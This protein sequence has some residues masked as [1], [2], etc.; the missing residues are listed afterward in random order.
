MDQD[1]LI[2]SLKLQLRLERASIALVVFIFIG[3]W[4]VG[5]FAGRAYVITADGKPLAY[6]ATHEAAERV[7]AQVK[8]AVAGAKP[9]D[10]SFKESVEIRK[11]PSDVDVAPEDDAVKSVL[12]KVSLR[13]KKHAILVEGVPAVAVDSEEDAGAVLEAAKARF[14]S[15]VESLME[16]PQFKEQV[17]VRR[18]PVDLVL[19]QP[20]IDDAVNEL[21][22][23]GSGS[24]VYAVASGDVASRIAMRH[25][26]SLSDLEALNPSKNLARLQIGQELRVS[27]TG[28]SGKRKLT[29]VVRNRESK[30]EQIPYR[31]E[32]ISSVRM[33][34]G[35]ESELS[36]GRN[37]L[38]QVVLATSYENGIRVGSE[39]VEETII[40]NP[41]PRRVAVG[42]RP[43]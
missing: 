12:G 18:M 23:G 39:I 20:K 31:T 25:G 24:S 21:F 35:K 16:E 11:A 22:S 17:D 30:T 7:I 26:M 1:K 15:M 2:R 43:R 3:W 42:I 14:G 13:V 32:S 19:Y 34:A 36:P 4:A 28:N 37:G 40:R 27:K 33:F 9:A 6:V 10:V 29:V 38:R 5:N 41:V 8:G